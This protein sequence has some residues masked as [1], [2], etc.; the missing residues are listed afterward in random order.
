MG[1]EERTAPVDVSAVQIGVLGQAEEGEAVT[2]ETADIVRQIEEGTLVI[3]RTPGGKVLL[4]PAPTANG[5]YVPYV[6]PLGERTIA[7]RDELLRR[8]PCQEVPPN[9]WTELAAKYGV[10]RERVRQIAVRY[11]MKINRALGAKPIYVCPCGAQVSREGILC[12]ECRWVT[13][14][15]GACGGPVRRLAR[16]LAYPSR[17]ETRVRGVAGTAAYSGRVFCNRQCF[18]R[19]V[20]IN[21]GFHAHPENANLGGGKPGQ[22]KPTVHGTM[23]AYSN[24]GCRCDECKA[25]MRDYSRE[26]RARK[27]ATA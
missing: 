4:E 11:G 7:I 2:A 23:N 6:P 9:T 5:P 12:R 20:G 8:F 27:A 19:W 24:R 3:R 17:T 10:T 25:A 21:A 22:R 13:L 14:P 15:C 1:A 26:A 18:G 16:S